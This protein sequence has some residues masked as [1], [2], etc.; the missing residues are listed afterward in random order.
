[1][2]TVNDKGAEMICRIL[3]NI[4]DLISAIDKE[5]QSD[6][7]KLIEYAKERSKM[8][9]RYVT[10]YHGF[11]KVLNADFNDTDRIYYFIAR[12]GENRHFI[13]IGEL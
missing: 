9:D 12:D 13:R 11:E 1:M 4:D 5:I 2:I 8:I 3:D 7:S 6:K 10:M